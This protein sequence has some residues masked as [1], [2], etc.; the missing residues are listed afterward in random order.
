MLNSRLI[1]YFVGEVSSKVHVLVKSVRQL[2]DRLVCKPH[3]ID[4]LLLHQLQDGSAV[5]LSFK[6]MV[7]LEYHYKG[8][9]HLPHYVLNIAGKATPLTPLLDCYPLITPIF[10][11]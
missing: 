6:V 1:P 4:W 10:F 8:L 7:M 5:D 2:G 11:F 3:I 9:L